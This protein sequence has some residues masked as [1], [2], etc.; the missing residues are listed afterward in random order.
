MARPAGPAAELSP[1]TGGKG[2]FVAEGNTTDLAA[3]GY[4]QDEYAVSGTASAYRPVGAL[5]AD[6]R[7]K[8]VADGS[9]PYKTR[10]VVRR[11][12]D[13]SKFSGTVVVEWLNVSGGVDANPDWVTLREEIMRKGDIWVGVSA[14]KIGVMGGPVLV[15]VPG[16]G[17][18]LTGKGLIRIDPARYGTLDQPGD[19]YSYDIFTQVARALRTGQGLSGAHP[20]R[21]IATGESQ[22]A[23]AM[24]SYYD[25]IQPLTKAFDG[26]FVH[27]RGGAALPIVRPGQT[28]DIA[29]ALQNKPVIFRTDLPE[30]VMD[31]QT[32]TDVSS[33]LSSYGARQPDSDT[34]RLWEV[35]GTAHAD[36]HLVGSQ[37]DQMQCGVPINDG[38]MHLVAKA[39]LRAL[40]TWMETGTAPVHAARID[41]KPGKT[42]TVQRDSDGIALGGVR[43]PPVDVPVVVL[44]GEPGPNPS[45]ICLLL[46]ST[47]PLPAARLAELYP[48]RAAYVQRYDDDVQKTIA[49]GFVLPE[50]KAALEAFAQP[51]LVGS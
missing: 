11:P 18:E 49:A 2:V 24:V 43:T 41:V 15:K 13:T 9:A 6:G 40:T 7:W 26:F 12:T 42:P 39:A 3:N 1:L 50:D 45:V 31:I 8:L 38:P 48:S 36:K 44:S 17:S 20:K 25:G 21:L 4:T 34:F 22:S 47:K 32:E 28:A 29:G 33:I 23:F 16:P 5:S 35:V 51:A 10:I 27:S 46:G 19:A 30:P 14:Q 37:A